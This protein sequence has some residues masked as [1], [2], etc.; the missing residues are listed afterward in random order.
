LIML[1]T[2]ILLESILTMPVMKLDLK[3]II[4]SKVPAQLQSITA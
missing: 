4:L 1:T 3:E 2:D